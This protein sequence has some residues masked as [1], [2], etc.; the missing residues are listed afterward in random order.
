[1]NRVDVGVAV[2]FLCL[3]VWMAISSL[4]LPA[5]MGRLPGPGFFPMVIG[6]TISLLAALLL[7]VTLRAPDA[8][9]RIYEIPWTRWRAAGI[10]V[11][12]LFVYILLWNWTPFV[13]RTALLMLLLLRLH[14][15]TWRKSVAVSAA[16][17]GAV[18][19]AFQYGLRVALR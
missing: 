8:A 10:T 17:T 9:D 5:G 7:I 3:G 15:E 6:A 18:F 16:L 11:A 19:L 12:L 1:V 2:F 13:P 14:G 4:A